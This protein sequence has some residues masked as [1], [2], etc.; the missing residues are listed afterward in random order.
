MSSCCR[1]ADPQPSSVDLVRLRW[2]ALRSKLWALGVHRHSTGQLRSRERR[3]AFLLEPLDPRFDP[4]CCVGEGGV[5]DCHGSGGCCGNGVADN[6]RLLSFKL[7]PPVLYRAQTIS[8][9]RFQLSKPFIDLGE[10]RLVF[11]LE[12]EQILDAPAK[13]PNLLER[14]SRHARRRAGVACWP[15]CSSCPRTTGAFRRRAV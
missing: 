3:Q 1:A 12:F 7:Q 9:F 4:G 6:L 2:I 8:E 11:S 13:V 15:V 10:G 14:R 5:R